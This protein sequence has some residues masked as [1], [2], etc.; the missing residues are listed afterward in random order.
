MENQ[1]PLIKLTK[2]FTLQEFACK[3]GSAVPS[4]LYSN[5]NSLAF[6]LQV[7]RE[8]LNRPIVVLS[9]YRTAEY[10]KKVGGAP[11]SQHLV[12]RAA[13][14]IVSGISPYSLAQIIE[15]LIR[16]EFMKQGGIGLYDTFTHYDVRG[17]K[18]R[19]DYRK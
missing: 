10:N 9:G 16:E 5:L 19:W 2:N 7:L 18:S 6:N 11:H 8:H 1:K 13:D 17:F 14:I 12:A 4:H 15:E 3:D